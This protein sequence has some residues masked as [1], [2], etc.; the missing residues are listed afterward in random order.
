MDMDKKVGID[1][2]SREGGR[3]GQGTAMGEKKWDNCN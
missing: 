1:C 3:A 2:G